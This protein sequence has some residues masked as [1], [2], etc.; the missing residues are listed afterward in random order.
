MSYHQFPSHEATPL[1]NHSSDQ[2]QKPSILTRL[3]DHLRA[4]ITTQ[5]TDLLLIFCYL[6]TGL[7]DSAAVFIW[8]SFVSMQTGNTVYLGLGL[9][10]LDTGNRWTKSAI[11]I[12]SFCVGS[13]CF[14]HFHR[15]FRARQRWVLALSF[16]VQMVCVAVAAGIVSVHHPNKDGEGIAWTTAVPLALVAFQSSG[17]ALTSRVLKMNGLTSVVLTSVYCDLFSAPGVLG[18]SEVEGRRRVGAI[19]GLILGTVIGGWWAKSEIGLEGA[20]W[21]TVGCKGIIAAAWLGWAEKV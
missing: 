5:W 17:Q 13:F 14:G 8:G 16:T 12:T 19:A 11:S 3:R 21:T 7:L 4:E 20:L 18:L 2:D 1:L 15:M 6:I 9:S 10:G